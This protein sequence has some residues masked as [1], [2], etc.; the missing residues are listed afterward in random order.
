[1]A[2]A[3]HWSVEHEYNTIMVSDEGV[4]ICTLDG[5]V[6][7]NEANARLIA[8]CENSDAIKAAGTGRERR[9]QELYDQARAAIS[10]AT[11]TP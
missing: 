6:T 3:M 11:G 4:P 7:D 5:P 2:D 1:M 9:A 8:A 10:K